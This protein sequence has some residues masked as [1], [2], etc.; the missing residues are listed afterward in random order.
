MKTTYKVVVTRNSTSFRLFVR[1]SVCLSVCLSL[2]TPL[3]AAKPLTGVRRRDVVTSLALVSADPHS[4]G[5]RIQMA[6]R[7]PSITRVD[8]WIKPIVVVIV[9]VVMKSDA[10][11]VPTIRGI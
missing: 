11:Q 6:S 4:S 8:D 10:Q 9:I 1:S 7:P 3:A 2:I 5:R